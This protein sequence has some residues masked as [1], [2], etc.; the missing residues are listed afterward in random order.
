MLKNLELTLFISI[1]YTYR[2][3]VLEYLQMNVL[4]MQ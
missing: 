3:I 2:H 4:L 1:K